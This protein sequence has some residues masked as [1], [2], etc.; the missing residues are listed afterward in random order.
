MERV[1]AAGNWCRR[2]LSVQFRETEA[3]IE[4]ERGRDA[5]DIVV[6]ITGV[7]SVD[8]EAVAGNQEVNEAISPSCS[9]LKRRGVRR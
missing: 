1:M 7:V 4:E 9:K 6:W 2:S 8:G 3:Y 5:T